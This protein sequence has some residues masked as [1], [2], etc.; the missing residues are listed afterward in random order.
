[1][2]NIVNWNG[3]TRASSIDD[4]DRLYKNIPTNQISLHL[5]NSVEL[6]V[7]NTNAYKAMNSFCPYFFPVLH[8]FHG[9]YRPSD[10]TSFKNFSFQSKKLVD[11][12]SQLHNRK[13]QVNLL[14]DRADYLNYR[15]S[16]QLSG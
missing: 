5:I 7:K 14:T 13:N 11:L 2:G 15:N 8:Q 3:D 10:E 9:V 1:L 4:I 16:H 12:L 6:L